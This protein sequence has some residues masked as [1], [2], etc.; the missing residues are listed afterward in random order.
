[1]AYRNIDNI[2]IENARIMFR[3]FSGKEDQYNRAGNRNFCVVIDDEETADRLIEDGWNVRVLPARDEGENP[4]YYMNVVV[5]FKNIPPNCYMIAGKNKTYLDEESI[6]S[7]DYAE[8]R[9]CDLVISPYQ[10]EV[11]GKSG[12]KA[13][14]KTGYFVIEQDVFAS[15][16]AD[17][18]YDEEVPF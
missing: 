5:S 15:K 9:T 11:N 6:G 13:Y 4:T 17:E 16:Y 18:Q 10:W 2:S 7:L 3:N 12:V 8:L 1:M 14:L